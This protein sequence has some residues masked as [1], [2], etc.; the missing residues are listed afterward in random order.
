MP[1]PCKTGGKQHIGINS[2]PHYRTVA[3]L[4]PYLKSRHL[5]R[6]LFICLLDTKV[7][8]GQIYNAAVN[9]GK[10]LGKPDALA[11]QLKLEALAAVYA[12]GAEVSD[13]QC[14]DPR[15]SDGL[16]QPHERDIRPVRID[17]SVLA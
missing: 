5:E 3:L 1:F 8:F 17:I 15:D 12:V 14:R 7:R 10:A 13:S 2:D 11:Q 4:P 16:G 9:V 6:Q